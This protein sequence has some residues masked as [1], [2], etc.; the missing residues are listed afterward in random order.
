MEATESSLREVGGVGW[1]RFMY[2]LNVLAAGFSAIFVV[3][4]VYK[5]L[6]FGAVSLVVFFAPA[7]VFCLTGTPYNHLLGRQDPA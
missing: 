4:I 5:S 2:G 6:R 1:M 7:I 3:Q